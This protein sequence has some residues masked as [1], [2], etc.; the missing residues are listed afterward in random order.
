MAFFVTEPYLINERFRRLVIKLQ[1]IRRAHG[2]RLRIQRRPQAIQ[3]Q[4]IHGDDY[5]CDIGRI[6][7]RHPLAHENI[8]AK[9]ID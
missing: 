8:V 5:T 3:D 6:F 9:I 7:R 2:I 1:T 4:R